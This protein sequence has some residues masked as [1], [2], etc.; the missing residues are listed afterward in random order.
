MDSIL[1]RKSILFAEGQFS[2]DVI[3]YLSNRI[4]ELG[5]TV[6]KAREGSSILLVNP[7]H[8]TYKQE[9][10]HLV[11]LK[12]T[13]RELE[14]P[15]I[16]SYHWISN[17]YYLQKYIE[18]EEL[19][20]VSPIFTYPS[21]NKLTPEH[22]E[23]FRPIKSWVSVNVAREQDETPD[24]ARD[25]LMKK[26]ECSGTINVNKRSHADLLMVDES[27]QFAKKI[28]EEKDKHHR[29]W[30]KIAERDWVDNCLR[31]KKLIWNIEKEDDPEDDDDKDSFIED[32]TATIK[33]KGLGRPTGQPRVD[34]TPSDDDFLCRYLAAHH[35]G[36][37]WASRK[38]Y[39]NLYA[40]EYT[41][42]KRHSAQSWHERYKKNST[43]FEK[44]VRGLVQDGVD[45]TL[46]T[47][48]EREKAKLV[49]ASSDEPSVARTIG[50]IPTEN[51]A[52][53]SRT[54][55]TEPSALSTQNRPEKRKLVELDDEE[56]SPSVL[57]PTESTS[58]R[59]RA[60]P[61]QVI[62]ETSNKSQA[63]APILP[64]SPQR[65]S[66]AEERIS[67]ASRSDQVSKSDTRGHSGPRTEAEV[68]TAEVSAQASSTTI[69]ASV[70]A[71]SEAPT[72]QT[73]HQT[74]LPPA[75]TP[76]REIDLPKPAASIGEKTDATEI[77]SDQIRR[78]Q[79]S[80]PAQDIGDQTMDTDIV[81]RNLIDDN[82]GS[83]RSAPGPSLP[84]SQAETD[85]N[86]EE[87]SQRGEATQAILA[88]FARAQ[89]EAG[90]GISYSASSSRWRKPVKENKETRSTP[91]PPSESQNIGP[92][93]S[94]SQDKSSPQR[95][96]TVPPS[97]NA[98]SSPMHI[99]LSPPKRSETSLQSSRS[100]PSAIDRG[101]VNGTIS[102]DGHTRMSIP[103]Q[104]GV[105][106]RA[107]PSGAGTLAIANERPQSP[108]TQLQAIQAGP[109][110]T[111]ETP[112]RNTYENGR[113]TTTPTSSDLP[114]RREK[115][116]LLRDRLI[117]SASKRRKTLDRMSIG[118]NRSSPNHSSSS[119][120]NRG[121][122]QDKETGP[123]M[124]F[125]ETSIP[126]RP[127]KLTPQLSSPSPT[128]TVQR[129]ISPPLSGKEREEKYIKGKSLIQLQIQE[130]KNRITNLAKT[131]NMTTAEVVNFI[132]NSV[133]SK[134][135]S[136]NKSTGERYW[137]EIEKNLKERR[138]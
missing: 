11:Y 121:H 7:S 108:Q 116:S 62:D 111:I 122:Y 56:S 41:H 66:P 83:K 26:L 76:G 3:T 70:P 114:E 53:P 78:T 20:I 24:Q 135:K 17:L 129:A 73:G 2:E 23:K 63:K 33:G 138:L 39:Q 104:L 120:R 38:T 87:E 109:S 113:T 88:D 5:G 100:A 60:D 69:T 98:Q 118:S 79:R 72:D 71:Q 103:F 81:D 19:E 59:L 9:I 42:S 126:P 132:N 96:I 137:D 92:E 91:P 68:A 54:I 106:I 123:D 131:Y 48:K 35:P 8:P 52:G 110:S 25:N 128:V 93:P 49:Q 36:G 21:S 67:S 32:S 133:N 46:K 94:R 117:A 107:V 85:T 119:N 89:A 30:Q 37:S 82:D 84:V 12:K 102:S 14:Q 10:E 16:I 65:P 64:K 99:I 136:K 1:W 86:D 27:S 105:D 58:K 43:S 51:A 28:Y 95:P 90:R 112:Q 22:G 75:V 29:F 13:Y 40:S 80:S 18:P 97:A 34:Y 57:I 127:E 45:T 15:K 50:T 77:P 125:R 101:A 124:V 61:V 130:Y 134:D 31:E 74:T 47:R 55:V 44:R 6:T 4:T 115:H